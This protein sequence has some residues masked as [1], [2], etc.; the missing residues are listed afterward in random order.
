MALTNQEIHRCVE[1]MKDQLEKLIKLLP[2]LDKP[3]SIQKR[4]DAVKSIDPSDIR[5]KHF[6]ETTDFVENVSKLLDSY[7]PSFV[8]DDHDYVEKARKRLGEHGSAKWEGFVLTMFNSIYLSMEEYEDYEDTAN[9]CDEVLWNLA[10]KH[11]SR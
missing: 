4:I 5:W 1:V 8:R 3:S 7:Y 10:E 2:I 9:G 6:V 11:L